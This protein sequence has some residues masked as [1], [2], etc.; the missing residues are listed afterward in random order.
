LNYDALGR[1]TAVRL[2]DNTT[3]STEFSDINTTPSGFN[4]TFVTVTDQAGKKRRQIADSLGRIVRV[5]EPDA[6]G[7]LGAVDAPN[8]PTAYEYDGNDNLSKVTQSD[9]TVTQER[10]FKYDSLSRLT[11]ERQ[12]EA[13][14]TLNDAGVKVT[15]GGLWTKV[16]K[17]NPSGLLTEGTDARGVKT[18]FNYDGLNRVSSVIYTGETGYQTPTVT[19]TYDQARSGFY[20]KGALTRVETSAVGDAPATVTEFDY[21]LMNRVA[22]HRQSIGGQNFNLEY[23]YNLAGQL[24]SEKY[25]S[26]KIVSTN[27]DASGRLANTADQGR[28]YLSGLQY[29]SNGGAVSAMTLGNGIQESF[30]YNGNLQLKQMTWAKDGNVIQRYD[31]TFGEMNSQNQLKNNGKLTQIDSY[32]GGGTTNPTK[33]FAQ[34]FDYDAVGRLK[35]ETETRGDN[36]QQGYKQIFDY[37]RFGNRYLKAADNPISQNP[38]LPTPIEAN[39]IDKEKNRLAANTGTIYD[40]AGNVTTDNKFRNLKYSYDAN[41]RMYKTSTMDDLNQA[42]SIYD[43]GGMR[44]ASQINGVWKFFVYDAGGK[45]VAEYGGT[46]SSDE[47]GIKYIHQDAQGSTRAITSASGTVKARSDYAAFGEEINSNIGQ[48]TAQGY[49][50]SDNLRQKYA[51]T[52]RDEASGLDH[53]WFRKNENRAGR[54]TSPDP[55]NGSMNLGD[56]QSFNR[57]SYVENQPT[58]FV[59]PSGLNLVQYSCYDL[60]TYWHQ[61]EVSGVSTTT[62]CHYS[63][64]GGN[65]GSGSEGIGNTNVITSDDSRAGALGRAQEILRDQNR[66]ADFIKSVLDNA[67]TIA[68]NQHVWGTPIALRP[69][70]ITDLNGQTHGGLTADYALNLYSNA[71]DHIS[72]SGR[73]GVNGTTTTYGTTNNYSDI[74]WNNEFYGLTV[75]NAAL[76]IIHESLHLI[77]NFSDAILAQAASIA[78]GGSGNYSGDASISLNQ[79]IANHCNP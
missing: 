7:N 3:V 15:T 39:N 14:A 54:W 71:T 46:P 52:E 26:G 29:A 11:N 49:A 35:T 18:S 19:Y 73:S 56:P 63:S 45:M 64:S 33:Q 32:N 23:G 6:N 27:Y 40:D 43:A 50:S 57:Y 55:Y 16:L 44:V 61:G 8:Q 24:T 51:L 10:R 65:S 67:F 34:K 72:R 74:S 38:L 79:Q 37:D 66:C 21:D 48:R 68:G 47:G 17:Y 77:P 59:D 78:S 53:T 28:T 4:K 25:P 58:N 75:G 42:N 70:G 69:E 60:N 2:Q 76:Q 31:Y 9:G 62:I 5:D 36:N 41:G 22:K 12:V 1:T 30:D 13:N 20:N